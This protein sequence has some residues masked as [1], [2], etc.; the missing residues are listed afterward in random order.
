MLL[1][2]RVGISPKKTSASVLLSALF[3]FLSLFAL[4]FIGINIPGFP[5]PGVVTELHFN[6]G[7]GTTTADASGNGHIGTLVN[8]PT[9]GPGKYGQG[10]NFNGTNSYVNIA[11]HADYTLTPTQSYSWS[12]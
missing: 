3:I 9:W 5:A 8:G 4:S 10:L 1:K 7:A 11:D 12:A 6:E 2:N